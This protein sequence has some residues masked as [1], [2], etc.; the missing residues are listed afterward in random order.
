M[1]ATMSQFKLSDELI[2]LNVSNLDG[3]YLASLPYFS[4][5]NFVT[6]SLKIT[7]KLIAKIIINMIKYL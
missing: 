3:L 5:H 4:L 7:E 2:N 1:N 6:K